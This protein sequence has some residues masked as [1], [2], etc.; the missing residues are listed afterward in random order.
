MSKLLDKG[1]RDKTMKEIVSFKTMLQVA[2]NFEQSDTIQY[3]N[4]YNNL[5]AFPFE[6]RL[7]EIYINIFSF[8][9]VRC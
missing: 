8:F 5:F 6:I 3:N 9:M 2:K 4:L 1:H 7:Q